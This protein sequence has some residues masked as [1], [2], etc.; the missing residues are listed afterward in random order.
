MRG[1]SSVKKIKVLVMAVLMVVSSSSA[2]FAQ[3]NVFDVDAAINSA[4]K[5]SYSI[6]MQNYSVESAQNGVD[7]AQDAADKASETLAIND[8]MMDLKGKENKT[9]DEK[10]SLE[11]F[12]PLNDDQRYELTK[13]KELGP[14]EAKYQLT[15]ATNNKEVAENTLKL[16][17]YSQYSIL[18]NLKDSMDLEQNKVDNLLA[19]Y[20]KAQLQMELGSISKIDAKKSE[21]SY[22]SEK[23]VLTKFQ[24]N[25]ETSQMTM[26]QVIGED[27]YKTYDSFP[28]DIILDT[29]K[30]KTLDEYL[31]DAFKNRVEI[32]NTEGNLNLKKAA[33][34]LANKEYP[35]ESEKNN[36][37]AKYDIDEAQ[38]NLDMLK[39]NVQQEI[40]DSYNELTKK[41][42]TIEYSQK[43]FNIA[44]K[45]YD[46]SLIR[47]NLGMISK[48]DLNS[49]EITYKQAENTLKSLERD[50]WL[51]QLKMEYQCGK[52]ITAATS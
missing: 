37:S 14:L 13:T 50:L 21:A 8:S 30:I 10:K 4:L 5:N 38:N 32:V 43:A 39:L 29:P 9:E 51:A 45:N 25:M 11:R 47:Y 6:K 31:I 16:N 36:Q 12:V 23:P 17:I 33:Y 49:S 20:K 35:N 48:I 1:G 28:K 19:T 18:M 40:T 52:G 3:G 2:A 7:K 22:V 41:A 44:K 24:R 34:E 26:N 27:I 46:E 42:K 15:V